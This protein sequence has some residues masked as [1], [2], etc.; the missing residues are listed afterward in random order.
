MIR[1]ASQNATSTHIKG[2]WRRNLSPQS[3]MS[4]PTGRFGACPS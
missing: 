2:C 4:A 1:I 3:R